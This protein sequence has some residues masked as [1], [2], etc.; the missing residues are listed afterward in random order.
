MQKDN[1]TT[2]L[3][4]LGFSS[5]ETKDL[6]LYALNTKARQE[7]ML[8]WLLANK[9]SCGKESIQQ[10]AQEILQ[11]FLASNPY[12][13]A[14]KN[15][16]APKWETP[17]SPKPKPVGSTSKKATPSPTGEKKSMHIAEDPFDQLMEIFAKNCGHNK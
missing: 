11:G 3:K 8:S 7:Q 13:S 4:K 1:L 5:N 2:T 16:P 15:M 6:L 17:P 14:A 9:D 12:N 10:K